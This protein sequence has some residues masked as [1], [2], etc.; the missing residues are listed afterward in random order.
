MKKLLLFAALMFAAILS[1]A[2]WEPDVRLTNDPGSSFPGMNN[3]RLIAASGDSVHV[4]WFDD[5]DGNEEIYYKRS[6]DGG[7][8]WG[9]DVRLTNNS[10]LSYD[11]CI[12]VSGSVVHVA[13]TDAR[14][15]DPNREIY[16]KRSEDGGSTWG[17]DIRLTNAPLS[18]ESPSM[19][20]SGSVLH[21]VWYDERNDPTGNWY[22]DIYYKCSTDG[23]LTWG[24][25]TRLTSPPHNFYSGFPCVAVSGSVVHVAWEDDR[26]GNYDVY[27]KNSTDGGLTWGAE[28]QL[29]NNP[30]GQSDPCLSVSGSVVHVVWH[31]NRYSTNDYEIFYKR[32]TDGGMTWGADTRLTNDPNDS[33]YPTI[34]TSG[35]LVHVVWDDNRD[36]NYEIYYKESLDAGLTWGADTRLTNAFGDSRYAYLGLSGSVVHIIWDDNRYGN[37]DIYYKRNPTGNV[38]VGIGNA[39]VNDP[40]KQIIIYPN[41]AS[42]IIHISFNNYSNLTTGQADEK[43][44]LT[45]R[46]ILGEELLSKQ[47]QNNITVIDVS[48]LQ[49]GLYFAEI[50]S[51]NKQ[52]VSTKLI[53][54]K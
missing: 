32:S 52:T 23:G 45:I 5:R 7:L 35:S 20:I 9:P 15:G 11:P 50:K 49:K 39:L 4:V 33:E 37:E 38:P 14:N 30:A 19:A 31:D 46:N 16:Y 51:G 22:T 53:I 27:Y 54:Q 24:T 47:I 26:N 10:A 36:G 13:W 28:T 18:S 41:P 48:G 3:A 34:A 12:L 44:I 2:Q 42:T 25:D 1:R 8:T 21:V 43:T 6:T 29:T 40:W 17:A